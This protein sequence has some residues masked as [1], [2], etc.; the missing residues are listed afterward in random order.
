MTSNPRFLLTY[1]SQYLYCS[2]L[3][4]S[5]SPGS[6][7][8]TH[9][10]SPRLP[11]SKPR[12]L[13]IHTHR[14]QFTFDHI[15]IPRSLLPV[16]VLDNTREPARYGNYSEQINGLPCKCQTLYEKAKDYGQTPDQFLTDIESKH[17]KTCPRTEDLYICLKRCE[18][19]NGNKR[20]L[21]LA[22]QV[23]W[24]LLKF[25][26]QRSVI[27]SIQIC[28]HGKSCA[29]DLNALSYAWT[30]FHDQPNHMTMSLL[31]KSQHDAIKCQEPIARETCSAETET[32]KLSEW[33]KFLELYYNGLLSRFRPTNSRKPATCLELNDYLTVRQ[34]ENGAI[35]ASF[36][37]FSV[38][39]SMMLFMTL[40]GRPYCSVIL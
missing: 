16:D 36:S 1:S 32:H 31:C 40:F 30:N 25:C 39:L 7:L 28:F 22:R 19:S 35:I 27:R 37:K 10:S 15:R 34:I 24:A 23:N 33:L 13:L 26:R 3:I 14:L 2:R 11:R 17:N 4:T 29:N 12:S 18:D 21:H 20:D 6:L 38:M 9:N 5:A 8:P